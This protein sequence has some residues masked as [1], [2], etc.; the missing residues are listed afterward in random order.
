MRNL[1]AIPSRVGADTRGYVRRVGLVL[2]LVLGL[3]GAVLPSVALAASEAA[4]VASSSIYIVQSGDTLSAIAR[5][6]GTTV[7]ALMHINHLANANQIYVG[8]RLEVPGYSDGGPGCNIYTV[9]RGDTLTAIARRFG[10]SV[11]AL[12]QENNISNTSHITVG[13]HLCIPNAGPAPTPGHYTVQR[14]DTLTA[15]AQRFGTTVRA[16][17]QINH[18]GNVNQIYVGQVLRLG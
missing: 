15:I 5:R 4:P 10:V 1:Y 16:L 8:Q 14:G 17:Q 6:F 2:M 13:Q 11:H 3:V 9:Q 18:L 7:N 12:A